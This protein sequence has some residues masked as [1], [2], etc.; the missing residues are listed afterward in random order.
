MGVVELVWSRC[1]WDGANGGVEG[2]NELRMLLM[3]LVFLATPYREEMDLS[4]WDPPEN[5]VFRDESSY[6]ADGLQYN[7]YFDPR[8]D[9]IE[10]DALNKKSC[11]QVLKILTNK[12]DSEIVEVE[13]DMCFAAL[14]K[15]IVNPDSMLGALKNENEQPAKPDIGSS[16]LP[17]GLNKTEAIDNHNTK[18]IKTVEFKDGCTAQVNNTVLASPVQVRNQQETPAETTL[19]ERHASEQETK[20]YGSKS[21][22]KGVKAVQINYLSGMK[23]QK[24]VHTDT[25]CTTEGKNLK[26][27]GD[28]Y[29]DKI[30]KATQQQL[31]GAK[32]AGGFADISATSQFHLSKM[33]ETSFRGPVIQENDDWRNVQNTLLKS[34]GRKSQ[35]PRIIHRSSYNEPNADNVKIVSP[36][37]SITP[38][39]PIAD[40]NKMKLVQLKALANR[41]NIYG[42]SNKRKAYVQ[43]LLRSKLQPKDW[44]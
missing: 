25:D 23:G 44:S 5:Q 3:K 8:L 1:G 11:Q 40:I 20:E 2:D 43:Q 18:D 22:Q 4:I 17:E 6:P 21:T 30:I 33:S 10:E 7:L 38:S 24:V 39:P 15:K 42:V 28:D 13:D 41:H 35:D 34:H 31:A 37:S 29:G 9:V 12:A 36:M 16:N 19:E 32:R 26:R 27:G 14:N